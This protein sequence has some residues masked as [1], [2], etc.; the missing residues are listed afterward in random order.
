MHFAPGRF[1]ATKVLEALCCGKQV[2]IVYDE[3]WF[4]KI[5]LSRSE[6]PEQAPER[7]KRPKV[8][9]DTA[10]KKSST[11]GKR[12]LTLDLSDESFSTIN[13]KPGDNPILARAG[14]NRVHAPEGECSCE[15]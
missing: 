3:P 11:A 7:P 12:K 5:S 10:S 9:I 4:W 1:T 15:D 14:L 8:E 13:G 6:K 2:K